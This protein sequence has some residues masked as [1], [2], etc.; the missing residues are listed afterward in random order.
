MEK[1]E[2]TISNETIFQL[3]AGS[4]KKCF[5]LVHVGEQVEGELPY[6]KLI[7]LMTNIIDFLIEF[8]ETT[9]DN[10]S[11]LVATVLELFFGDNTFN[12]ESYYQSL[13]R[14]GVL[15]EV[16]SA[17]MSLSTNKDKD[18]IVFYNTTSIANEETNEEERI[19]QYSLRKK[20]ICF[21]KIKF[22]DL[23]I[24]YIYLGNHPKIYEKIES[25]QINSFFLFK[26]ILI[27]FRQLIFQIKTKDNELYQRLIQKQKNSSFVDILLDIYSKGEIFND[28]IEFPLITKLYLLIK[29]LQ[30]LYGDKI[31]INHLKKLKNANPKQNFP[32]NQEKNLTIDSYF[33]IRVHLFLEYLIL[34]VEIKNSAE[35]ND[36][37]NENEE[38]LRNEDIGD[39][40]KLIYNKI[41]PNFG[42]KE[43]KDKNREKISRQSGTNITFFIRPSLTFRLS[44]E[45]MANFENNVNRSNATDKY[46][47]LIKFS[48]YAL[49]EMIVN[50]HI[51]GNGRFAKFLSSISYKIIEYIN[52]VLIIVQNILL[53]NHFY[54]SP[55]SNPDIYDVKDPG[56][57]T[58][59]FTDNL[60]LA[61]IQVVFT[62]LVTIT[63]F[64]FKFILTFQKNVMD[65]QDMN[66]VFKKKKEMKM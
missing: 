6:D 36:E 12:S 30:E 27:H 25:K 24:S 26:I 33:A 11:T 58:K 59:Q 13:N 20:V 22:V 46:M 40:S 57:A 19:N 2:L 43:K 38:I 53:M 39:V 3:L 48:D 50:Q 34:K 42:E 16:L 32:L 65:Y 49:F 37:E 45:S 60:I 1:N 4:L 7:V 55:D 56:A 41:F 31:L 29:I 8:K 28:I 66:F 10:N 18:E 14:K 44:S 51:I 62:A 54:K 64:F 21:L 15:K 61:I 23:L 63:W 9:E 47:G 35:D 52:Y 5:Y 17:N